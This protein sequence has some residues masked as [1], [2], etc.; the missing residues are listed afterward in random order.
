MSDEAIQKSMELAAELREIARE[1]TEREVDAESATAALALARAMRPHLEGE[2]R[3][4]W[5]EL[6]EGPP[7]PGD[8]GTV[9]SFDTLSPVRGLLNPV[10]P[11]LRLEFGE[12]ADG[13][14]CVIGYARLS[15]VYEGPPHGVHGG[16]VA[17]MFDEILGNAQGLA[18]PP[19]VTAK[20]EVTYHHLTPID[21]EL[22]LEAW[23][24]ED[25]GRRV[26]ARA[27]CHAGSTLTARSNALFMR[28]D[29][30]AVEDRM[31]ARAAGEES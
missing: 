6:G 2:R 28:V 23:V 16:I 14:P 19:G 11:P 10:A 4:R 18:P 17:A 22:R 7:F 29:F 1:L 25:R 31:K 26:F 3:P 12:R 9:G 5:Y 30:K 21:E 20:L 13:T 27:T 24:T 15:A 8:S